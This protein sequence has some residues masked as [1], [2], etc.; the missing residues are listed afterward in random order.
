[1]RAHAT[2][3]LVAGLTCF[4]AHADPDDLTG[5]VLVAHYVPEMVHSEDRWNVY[6]DEYLEHYAIHSPAEVN[7]RIDVAYFWPVDWFVLAAWESED[8][9]WCGTEFGFGDYNGNIF[10]AAAASPCFPDE[11]LEIPTPGWPGPL[12]GTAFVTTTMPWTGNWVPVYY[13]GGYAYGYY[14][15]GR[16]PIAEDPPTGFVSLG[17]C[18]IPPSQFPVEPSAR[19]AMGINTDGIVPEFPPPPEPWACCFDTGECFLL[20]QAECDL[21]G[22]L[23]WLEGVTC[24]PNPCDQPGACCLIGLCEITVGEGACDLLGGVYQG[25][26]TT[27][28]PNP[29]VAVCCLPPFPL[30]ICEILRE[31]ECLQGGGIWNPEWPSCDPNPCWIYTPTAKTSWGRI[32]EMYRR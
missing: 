19:G 14:G 31:D 28:D 27:C 3:L 15:P 16:I 13:F 5:G 1:M 10:S 9:R 22:G 26:G 29:C 4:A 7:A 2:L 20:T 25:P 12:E 18:V 24:T 32:K 11:G 17:N 30:V 6:C 21:Q 8:K 23:A